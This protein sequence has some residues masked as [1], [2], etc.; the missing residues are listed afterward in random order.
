MM[1]KLIFIEFTYRPH[2][3]GSSLEVTLLVL[4]TQMSQK[5]M[6]RAKVYILRYKPHAC[7]C[8]ELPH[9]ARRLMVARAYN[10]AFI[11]LHTTQRTHA[12]LFLERGA[13][14]LSSFPQPPG[15]Y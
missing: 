12:R 13:A 9:L 15:E 7:L 14:F 11:A 6:L 2:V 5:P 3:L 1:S 8:I 10:L 4:R